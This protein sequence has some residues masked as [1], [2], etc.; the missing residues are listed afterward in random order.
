MNMC[1][2]NQHQQENGAL[3]IKIH[4]EPDFHWVA[5]S[6]SPQEHHELLK[7]ELSKELQSFYFVI[8]ASIV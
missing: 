2:P 8:S 5:E 4:N 6:H 1:Y 3:L 7:Y